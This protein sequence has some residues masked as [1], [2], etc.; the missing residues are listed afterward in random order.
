MSANVATESKAFEAMKG[1][2]DL[3]TDLRGGTRAMRAAHTKWLPRESLEE[4]PRYY[5]RLKRSTLFGAYSDTLGSLAGKPFSRPVTIAGDVPERLEG[6]TRNADQQGRSLTQF[7]RDI[8]ED[9]IHYGLAHVLVDMPQQVR[10][11]TRADVRDVRPYFVRIRPCDLHGWRSERDPKTGQTFP[12]AIRWRESTTVPDGDFGEKAVERVRVMSF[13][14]PGEP[15]NGAFQVWERTEQGK[16][17]LTAEGPHT[18]RGIPL[19]T[20]YLRR[21]GFMTG[22]PCLEDLAWANLEHWQSAS[23]QRELMRF[24][25]CPLWFGTGISAEERESFSLGPGAFMT[26]ENPEARMSVVEHSGAAIRAGAEDLKATEDRMTILGLQ[27]LMQRAQ[28]ATGE[29]IREGRTQS[30]AQSWV[31]SLEGVLREL[32]EAGATY[33]GEELA[34]EFKVD[35]FN[36]FSVSV[37]ATQDIEALIKARSAGEITRETFLAGL[38]RYSVLPDNLDV[39][40]EALAAASELDA[41]GEGG[42]G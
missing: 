12:R 1:A 18:F 15:N 41:F 22:A 28:T 25:R 32:Y 9:G 19:R 7:A 39:E 24:A 3:P 33:I 2:W 16:W 23:D 11:A 38:K 29:S 4:E 37:R 20:L 30:A 13:A 8:Y 42:E 40:A 21:T 5:A 27:P 31:Q 17:A 14:L 6:I 36:D 10:G 35:V 34:P 26:S